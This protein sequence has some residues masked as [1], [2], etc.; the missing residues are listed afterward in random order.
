MLLAVLLDL[1]M[2]EVLE[3]LVEQEEQAL[4][5]LPEVLAKGA[6]QVAEAQSS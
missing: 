3:V 5:R 6:A 4:L 2:L 1:I